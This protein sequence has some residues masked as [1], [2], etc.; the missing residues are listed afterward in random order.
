[1][2]FGM[3]QKPLSDEKGIAS[4]FPSNPTGEFV[5]ALHSTF[6]RGIPG[7]TSRIDVLSLLSV[8]YIFC[9]GSTEEKA[10][11][12]FELFDFNR[13]S[14]MSRDELTIM[15]ISSFYGI[16]AMLSLPAEDIETTC[17]DMTFEAFRFKQNCNPQSEFNTINEKEFLEFLQ[18]KLDTDNDGITTIEIVRFFQRLS[19]VLGGQ[20]DSELMSK[21]DSSTSSEY[22]EFEIEEYSSKGDEFM[23]VKPWIGAVKEPT[24]KMST[25]N[26]TP[27]S[28]LE[29]DWVYGYRSYDV[30]NNLHYVETGENCVSLCICRGFNASKV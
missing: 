16:C 21:L 5:E 4:L 8:Y 29:L 12:I 2:Q 6:R 22:E 14:S 23:A 20:E 1:M 7:P 15:F 9:K 25:K 10:K 11:A 30:R 3:C 24:K 17:E 26:S 13:N 27:D 18:D 28:M 19:G